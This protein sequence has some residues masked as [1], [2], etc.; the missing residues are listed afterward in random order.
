MANLVRDR[1]RERRSYQAHR[2]YRSS[3][4]NARENDYRGGRRMRRDASRDREWR[5][6]RGKTQRYR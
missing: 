3:E 6:H 5:Q 2:D 4:R 1:E